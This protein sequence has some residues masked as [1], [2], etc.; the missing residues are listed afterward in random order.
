MSNSNE[1]QCS[2]GTKA[3]GHNRRYLTLTHKYTQMK[4]RAVPYDDDDDDEQ[5]G[6]HKNCNQTINMNED[7]MPPKK[8]VFNRSHS[9]KREN[10]VYLAHN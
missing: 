1:N 8:S 10:Q 6:G 9:L 2:S 7:K 5:T 3:A 4:S